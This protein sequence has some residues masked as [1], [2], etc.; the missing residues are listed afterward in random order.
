MREIA[1]LVLADGTIFQGLRVGAKKKVCAEIVFNTAMAGYQEI[2]TDP[3]Y[4]EQIITFTQ[5]HIGN[6]GINERD[7]E[8][9]HIFAKGIVM[10]SLS[11]Y[12]NHY[13][14][15][16]SLENFLL[17]HDIPAITEVDTRFLTQHLRQY[18]SQ[19]ACIAPSTVSIE[20]AQHLA[21]T[22][23]GLKNKDL[24]SVVTTKEIYEWS[25]P[26][27]FI[28]KP[29][30]TACHI[31]VYDYGVKH[32][33][34]RYLVSYGAKVTVVPAKTPVKEILA[35]QADGVLL[36]NGPGDPAACDY[37]IENAKTL[38]A[39]KIPI[40]GICLGHQILA[41]ATGAKTEKMDSGHHGANHPLYCLE[42]QRVGI[43]SQ[44]HGFVVSDLHLPA[45]LKITHRS[46]FDKSIAGFIHTDLPVT[47]FQGHPEAGPGPSE[48]AEVLAN[49]VSLLIKK[50]K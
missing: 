27:D 43:S 7:H 33:I 32:S 13:L 30:N 16:E 4:A 31:V 39:K 14:S 40:L 11:T 19:A 2:L 20:M 8:S 34:L 36:S 44:N 5:P 29:A 48:L 50:R 45:Q 3:S 15:K 49:F 12:T 37:A 38:M 23:S 26:H 17:R 18:G 22:F 24:A 10:R 41:L 47:G 6:T 35:L 46:L 9:N 28:V 1:N 21:Q 42:T 25:S